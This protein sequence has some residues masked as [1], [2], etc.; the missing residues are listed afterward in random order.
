MIANPFNATQRHDRIMVL[1]G[2][3]A[4]IAA[5][6][7]YLWLGAGIEMDKMDMGAGQVMLMM[8][9]WTAGHAALVLLMWA[10]MMAAMMLPSAAPAILQVVGLAHGQ[11][12]KASGVASAVLFTAGYLMVWLAFS[13]AA[14]LLQWRLESADLLS[15][16]M[17]SRSEVAAGLLLVA[18][19]LYQLT[20]LKQVCLRRCR[21]C[22]DGLPTSAPPGARGMVE[23]GLRYGVSC[24]GC[25]WVVMG[26]LLV[27][28]VMNVFW[29]AAITIGVLAEKILPWG[30]GL[31]RLGGVGLIAWGS[32][33][34]A[35][36][37][38]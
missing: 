21:S 3:T 10:V 5:A 22:A 23:R 17:A 8:P 32:I 27:G 6:W 19:G 1:A 11:A 20:P 12:E 7:V 30:G 37:M 25:C 2:L 24:L 29:M 13:V 35:V 18:V 14:T 38:L 4:L 28:G 33:S 9:T 16:T 34:L 26:L 36:A 15:E 31:A